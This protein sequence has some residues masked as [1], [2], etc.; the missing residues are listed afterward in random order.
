[1]D[2]SMIVALASIAVAAG[3]LGVA[4]AA[5]KHAKRSATAAEAS[6]AAAKD[7]A[8]A[9][10][11]ALSDGRRATVRVELLSKKGNTQKYLV[12]NTGQHA[13]SGYRTRNVKING[14]QHPVPAVDH[15]AVIEPGEAIELTINLDGRHAVKD[16]L[17]EFEIEAEWAD[18][19]STEHQG[20]LETVAIRRP[21][22]Q[23]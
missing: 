20:W 17:H 6:A 21:R 14:S 2:A 7:S 8:D 22:E 4:I 18:G 15:P 10:V 19:N 16:R 13:A 11:G 23:A 3:S 1:M 9:A 5:L 12:R